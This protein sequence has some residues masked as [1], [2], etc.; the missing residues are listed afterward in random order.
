MNS[1]AIIGVSRTSDGP[2]IRNLRL[3]ELVFQTARA[4]L[5]DAGVLREELDHVVLGAC[6]ELDGRSISSMLMAAPAGAY[7]KDEIK[8]TDS[9]MHAFHLGYMRICCGLFHL[10]L[11]IS[12]AKNSESPFENVMSMRLDPF[13]YRGVGLNH[14]TTTALMAATYLHQSGAPEDAAA[15]VVVKNRRHGCLN[16]SADI[17]DP[18]TV[19]EVLA[20][21]WIA[22][23]VRSLEMAPLTD[24]A[25]AFVLASPEAIRSRHLRRDPIWIKG[26]GWSTDSYYLGQRDLGYNMSL[27]RAARQAFRQAGVRDVKQIDVFELED[28]SGYH[29][30]LAY[31]ALGLCDRGRA[32]EL[33]GSGAT[34]VDGRHP[35]N[36]SGGATCSNPFFCTGLVR[37]AEA[38]LQ[39]SGRAN[40]Y[41]VPNV[42][43]ALA[44]GTNGFANQGSSVIILGQS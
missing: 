23:P 31:E 22:H 40:G 30:L 24:G 7:L 44:Q 9:G 17:R 32:H 5:D 13:I 36:P 8:V 1:V 28:Q 43:T 4:A 6:D 29:E 2:R 37:V 34:D 3:E 15:R 39:V 19:E 26:I 38:Y 21:E 33:V 16:P 10:G 41:Q 11:V 27:E 14:T 35:V 42:R 12:W 20:S 18:L 25:V